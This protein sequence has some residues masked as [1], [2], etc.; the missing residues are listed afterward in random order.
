M[1]CIEYWDNELIDVLGDNRREKLEFFI[2]FIEYAEKV[3]RQNNDNESLEAAAILTDNI[4]YTMEKYVVDERPKEYIKQF[5]QVEQFLKILCKLVD[6]VA[7]K[8]IKNSNQMFRDLIIWEGDIKLNNDSLGLRRENINDCLNL[9]APK[10]YW[11]VVY[12]ARNKNAHWTTNANNQQAATILYS[13]IYV[14]V[15]S[16]WKYREKIISLMNNYTYTTVFDEKNYKKEIISAYEKSGGKKS[17]IPLNLSQYNNVNIFED[18]DDELISEL[19]LMDQITKYKKNVRIIGGAGVG[20]SR[21]LQHLQYLDA[22]NEN[23]LPIYIELKDIEHEKV[24]LLELICRRLDVSEEQIANIL[25]RNIHLY[26]DGVNELLYSGKIKRKICD[27]IE[28]F[29]KKY[30][31]IT[32]IITDRENTK[33]TIA[34]DAEKYI[35]CNMTKELMFQFIEKNSDLETNKYIK[36]LIEKCENLDEVIKTVSTPLMMLL[37]IR[38]VNSGTMKGEITTDNVIECYL[39]GLINREI[40][41]KGDLDAEKIPYLLAY[42]VCLNNEAEQDGEEKCYIRGAIFEAFKIASEKCCFSVESLEILD[43]IVKMGIMYKNE[44]GYVFTVKEYEDYFFGF[45]LKEG[46]LDYGWE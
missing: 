5:M 35:I 1:N 10:K 2:N 18:Y 26:L 7:Y 6:P 14:M 32:L 24:G 27:S 25:S 8:K 23:I 13:I 3:F 40:D 12:S 45:A 29:V 17:F 34:N 4:R 15:N 9:Q 43:L 22:H 33:V 39:E 38:A 46:L 20:K 44:Q 28:E 30:P 37:L 42:L 21:F 41:E 36:S 19:E 16:T 31:N 11:S